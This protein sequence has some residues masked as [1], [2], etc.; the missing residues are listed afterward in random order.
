MAAEKEKKFLAD[1]QSDN[2][3][4][5]YAAWAAGGE[6]DPAVIPEL[7]KL[8]AGAKPGVAK[9]ATE[10]LNRLVHSVG[11]QASGARRQGVVRGL[12]GLAEGAQP[13]WARTVALR[14]LSAVGGDETV[15]PAAKLLA[16][17]ELRE[18]AV[19]CLERIPGQASTAALMAALKSAP[20]DF[21]PRLLAA[22]GHRG[23]Q[24]AAELCAE[25]IQSSNLDVALAGMKALAR[26]GV[27]T[28]GELKTPP[29]SALSPFQ[30]LE[31]A[32][33]AVRYAEGLARNGAA[34]EAVKLYRLALAQPA[35]HLQ[36]AA[37][38]GLARIGT[39]EAAAIVFPALKSSQPKVRRTAQKA[40]DSLKG[41]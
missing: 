16:S 7:G 6:M 30:L 24:Q 15:A 27:K 12:I 11:K 13:A 8:I 38:V 17:A 1:L 26:I 28:A 35:E 14:H 36:C 21:K 5:R 22:L 39:A 25:A 40:W 19:F 3:G 31:F 37:V 33:S 34:A 10:A 20:D 4:V 9:A 29:T 2:A 32:D 18:E 41:A 23:D